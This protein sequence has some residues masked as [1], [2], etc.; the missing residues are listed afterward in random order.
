MINNVY[1]L[2]LELNCNEL[3]VLKDKEHMKNKIIRNIIMNK[4]SSIW[5]L[6]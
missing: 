3:F 5:S 2:G 1:E 4:C 6:I